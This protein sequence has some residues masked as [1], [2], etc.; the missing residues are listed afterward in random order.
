MEN[1][2]DLTATDYYYNNDIEKYEFLEIR[3]RG[4]KNSSEN[5]TYHF[6]IEDTDALI[7]YSG[8]YLLQKLKIVKKNNHSIADENVTLVNG[9]G[10]IKSKKLKIGNTEIE[11][12]TEYSSLMDQALRLINFTPDYSTSEAT[13]MLFYVDKSDTADK[14]ILKYD[15]TLQ[16]TTKITDFYKNFQINKNYNEGFAERWLLTKDSNT[17]FI[18][19]PLKHIFNFLNEYKKVISGFKVYF[20]FQRN[21]NEDML[22]TDVQNPNYKVEVEDFTLWLPYVEFKNNAAIKYKESLMSAKPEINWNQYRIIRSNIQLK[23]IS[24]ASSIPA[25]TDEV[26]ALYVIPQ[27]FDRTENYSKNNM[28]FDN[29]DMTECWLTVNGQTVPQVHYMMDFTNKDY[30]R[31]YNALLEA[32]LNNLNSETGCM[33]NYLNFGKLYPII[34]F[35]LSYHK[36]Y[37][38]LNNLHIEFNWKLRNNTQKD[39]VFYFILKERKRC[40]I[41]MEKKDIIMLKTLS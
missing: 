31:I 23:Y 12:N 9:G 15:G 19:T 38:S 37:T 14:Q 27:Y 39:Y 30:N 21:N 35:N 11:S 7:F 20:D 2:Y 34:C 25:T 26:L 1:I 28:V 22:Y 32:G 29:L 33:V 13:N 24:G 16:D 5:A 18:W 6:Y 4:N 3:E 17:V 8:G 36:N 41:D 40:L 10:L